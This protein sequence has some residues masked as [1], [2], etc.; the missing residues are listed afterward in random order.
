MHATLPVLAGIGPIWFLHMCYMVSSALMLY[1]Y[2]G[3]GAVRRGRHLETTGAVPM[4]AVA[5][6][7]ER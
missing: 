5:R 2:L 4:T 3:C 6:E 1:R 7:A